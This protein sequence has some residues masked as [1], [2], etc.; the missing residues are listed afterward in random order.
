MQRREA[1]LE[2]QRLKTEAKL[3]RDAER[4]GAR[5]EKQ[6]EKSRK[7]AL[8]A[9]RRQATPAECMKVSFYSV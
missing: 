2:I 8:A 5:C 4:E 7:Q 6:Y 9:A 3:R 1:A